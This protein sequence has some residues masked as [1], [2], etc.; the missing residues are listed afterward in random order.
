M[1]RE[2]IMLMVIA[3]WFRACVR[4]QMKNRKRKPSGIFSHFGGLFGNM[5]I[6]SDG[7]FVRMSNLLKYWLMFCLC[8]KRSVDLLCFPYKTSMPQVQRFAIVLCD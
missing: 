6:L 8:S 3:I 7:D 5:E 1:W 4:M 2:W